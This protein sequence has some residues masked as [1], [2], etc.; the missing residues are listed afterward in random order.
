MSAAE[1]QRRSAASKRAAAVAK[2]IR[3]L[4]SARPGTERGD[5]SPSELIDRIRARAS[6]APELRAPDDPGSGPG[7]AS[8]GG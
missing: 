3:A 1:T 2:R 7:Q 6:P 4:R 8:G 5:Y